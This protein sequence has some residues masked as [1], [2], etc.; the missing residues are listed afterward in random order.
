MFYIFI[1]FFLFILFFFGVLYILY[2]RDLYSLSQTHGNRN[3]NDDGGG[4]TTL[5]STC[6][7]MNDVKPISW[8]ALEGV[9]VGRNDV[10]AVVVSIPLTMVGT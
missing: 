2:N 8:Q 5:P 6:Y 10:V 4:S 9:T 7:V 3:N 1:L